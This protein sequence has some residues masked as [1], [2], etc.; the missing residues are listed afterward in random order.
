[1]KIWSLSSKKM[2]KEIKRK[3][4]KGD[5]DA[6]FYEEDDAKNTNRTDNEEADS[7]VTIIHNKQI[8]RKKRLWCSQINVTDGK[9]K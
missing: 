8:E 3:N 1:M 2:M 5:I 4:A 9:C 6:G 7:D